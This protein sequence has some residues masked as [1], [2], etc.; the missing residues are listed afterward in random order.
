MT[1]AVIVVLRRRKTRPT[2]PKRPLFSVQKSLESEIS[3]ASNTVDDTPFQLAPGQLGLTQQEVRLQYRPLP[4]K[5]SQVIGG[6]LY[7]VD[8]TV[9]TNK[10]SSAE[11][12]YATLSYIASADASVPRYPNFGTSAN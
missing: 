6:G 9:F 11:D 7:S 12:M 10:D 3:S 5:P 1:A 4:P 8:D 2:E